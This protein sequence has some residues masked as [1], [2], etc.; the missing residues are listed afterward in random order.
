MTILD[1]HLD[2]E[3]LDDKQL[4]ESLSRFISNDDDFR[5]L[6]RLLHLMQSRDL[7]FSLSPRLS[8]ELKAS[9]RNENAGRSRQEIDGT[10]F[11][12]WLE[13]RGKVEPNIRWEID[14]LPD[15]GGIYRMLLEGGRKDES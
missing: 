3:E 6:K 15:N 2:D 13:V 4:R 8:R 1:L 7:R 5:L 12:Q 10:A 14:T 11:L 9:A